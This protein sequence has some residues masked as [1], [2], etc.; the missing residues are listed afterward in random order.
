M[1]EAFL[2]ALKGILRFE[3]KSSVKT[4][5]FSIARNCYIDEMRKKKQTESLDSIENCAVHFELEYEMLEKEMKTELNAAISSLEQRSQN[6]VIMRMHGYSFAEIGQKMGFA[7]GSA[8]VLNH[9]AMKKLKE[10]LEK[11]G[12]L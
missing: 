2:R 12:S 11:E 10:V 1:Q 6:I 3:S 5:L 8:R 9:R 4:W 7:E